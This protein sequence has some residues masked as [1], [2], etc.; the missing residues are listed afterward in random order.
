MR[1]TYGFFT[2]S[3]L[4]NTNTYKLFNLYSVIIHNEQRYDKS[5]ERAIIRNGLVHD[6]IVKKIKNY[7]IER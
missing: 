1:I 6:E 3:N 2:F 5:I 4:T 7:I